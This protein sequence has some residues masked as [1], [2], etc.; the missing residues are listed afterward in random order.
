M[1]IG[2]IIT[3]FIIPKEWLQVFFF[4]WIYCKI[5]SSNSSVFTRLK[6]GISIVKYIKPVSQA[7]GM[8]S[9]FI[10]TYEMLP[11]YLVYQM[12]TQSIQ[13]KKIINL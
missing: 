6:V 4:L 1:N 5:S 7:K 3:L 9:D 2:V 10:Y 11:G 12:H 8:K 13:K